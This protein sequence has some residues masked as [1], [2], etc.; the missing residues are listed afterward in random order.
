M[1]GICDGSSWRTNIEKASATFLMIY[2]M[3][4]GTL[5]RAMRI[6]DRYHR[7]DDMSSTGRMLMVLTEGRHSPDA[8]SQIHH[9][10]PGRIQMSE[11]QRFTECLIFIPR[12]NVKTT[13]A[14]VH[15]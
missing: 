9:L 2:R 1:N 14:G 3:N 7:A 10:Q 4:D 15:G 13:F 8:V 5:K 6:R 11:D 12:K